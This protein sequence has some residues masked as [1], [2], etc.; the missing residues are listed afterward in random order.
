[1]AC[2]PAERSLTLTRRRS[3]AKKKKEED[4]AFGAVDIPKKIQAHRKSF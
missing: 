4:L 2:A 3:M 1:M